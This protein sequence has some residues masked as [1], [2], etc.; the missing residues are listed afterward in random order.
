MCPYLQEG[1][2]EWTQREVGGL[3]ELRMEL[4]NGQRGVLREEIHL[5]LA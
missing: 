1:N 5:T 2:D 4:L 3:L